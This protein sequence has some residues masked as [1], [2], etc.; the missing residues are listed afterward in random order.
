[1]SYA[2]ALPDETGVADAAEPRA[3]ELAFVPAQAKPPPQRA[4]LCVVVADET[5]CLVVGDLVLL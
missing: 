4:H 5:G 3:E 1:M 2:A